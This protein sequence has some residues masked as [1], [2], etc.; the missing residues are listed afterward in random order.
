[1]SKF[2]VRLGLLFVAI[3]W[4]Y[5]YIATADALE[6]MNATQMQ[7]LRFFLA[8]LLLCIIFFKKLKLVKKTTIIYGTLIGLVF[9]IGMTMHTAALATT[10]VSK[11]SFLVVTNAVFT[12]ILAFI[13]FREKIKSY[14]IP[15]L[16]IML[17]G[18][19]ILVFKIDFFN[20]TSS[21]SNLKTQSNFVLGDYLTLFSAIFFALQ[22][23]LISKY[24]KS[25]DP[26]LL[27]IFQLGS[28]CIFSLIY[29]LINKDSIP[30][31]TMDNNLL[32]SCIPAII[33]LAFGS[34]IGFCL[35]QI[36][37]KYATSTE[38]SLIFSTESLFATIFSVFLGYEFFGSFLVI[39]GILITLGIICAE[40]G[41]KF[42]EN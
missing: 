16:I 13:L 21:L 34:C 5:G 39:G 32:K 30:L 28:T 6:I 19:F 2:K 36:F 29:C 41:F 23:V 20:L 42:K 11:N 7:F 40:T 35:Q 10:T 26:I 31:I 1:M 33:Y 18:F 17:I 38:T 24:V 4:A 15:G 25:E 9:F 22:I 14:L 12:P 37:Q 27:V 3:I 8:T